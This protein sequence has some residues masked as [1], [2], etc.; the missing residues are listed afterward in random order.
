MNNLP[1]FLVIGAG[2]SGTTS[3]HEYLRQHPA[4]SLPARKETHFFICDKQSTPAPENYYGRVLVN[5]IYNLDDYL[6]EFEK[7]PTAQI[8]GEVCPTYLFYPNAPVNIKKYVPNVKLIAILRNP[9][10]R[11][12]S[13]FSYRKARK[14]ASGD[15]NNTLNALKTGTMETSQKHILDAGMY[16]SLLKRYYDTFP[17]ENIKV[18]LFEDLEQHPQQLMS[19]FMRFLGLQEHPFNV[20]ARYNRSGNIRLGWFYRK[21]RGS[22]LALFIRKAIS[23]KLYQG[24]R[25]NIEKV[26]FKDSERISADDRKYLQDIYREDILKLQGLINIDLSNWLA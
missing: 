4:I 23:R 11:F 21:Y 15:F 14:V 5:P 19:E 12:Y 16:Y 6:A 7:K 10:D 17:K 2:K 24:V 9:V 20:G 13:T 18:F 25:S 22:K 3:L 8:F 26:L 1:G